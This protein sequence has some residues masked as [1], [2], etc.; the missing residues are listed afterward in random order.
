MLLKFP[1]WLRKLKL[2]LVGFSIKEVQSIEA[3]NGHGYYADFA[4]NSTNS[5]TL[6]NKF[7]KSYMHDTF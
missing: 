4:N 6:L 5:Y 2:F 3:K 1:F 7:R